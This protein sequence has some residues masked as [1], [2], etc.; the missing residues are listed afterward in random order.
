M[1]GEQAK[2]PIEDLG[3]LFLPKYLSE[4]KQ[5]K[6]FEDL[7][8]FPN[9]TSL[10]LAHSDDEAEVF[11]GDV[12]Q[13]FTTVDVGDMRRQA[14]SGI[15]LSN[16]CDI[17]PEN[18]R[19]WPVRIAFSSIISV[20]KFRQ[21]LVENGVTEQEVNDVLRDIKKQQN[22]RVFYLP[23]APYGPEDDAMVFLDDVHSQ[24]VPSLQDAGPRLMWRLSQSGFY[25]FLLKLSIHF[26]RFR[27][28]IVRFP[29]ASP[30]T[31]VQGALS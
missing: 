27:E 29:D 11:Q 3:R 25:I 4:E 8:A 6:L 9:I 14:V 20:E 13:G 19:K 23:A 28:G 24:S 5:A 22:T 21:L 10:Y 7:A 2:P 1:S 18:K 15:V 16:S 26:C 30:D 17:A 12:W 31:N